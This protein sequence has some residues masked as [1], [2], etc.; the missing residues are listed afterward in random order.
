MSLFLVSC[1]DRTGMQYGSTFDVPDG[2][3]TA[4][5]IR[6]GWEEAKRLCG[7]IAAVGSANVCTIEGRIVGTLR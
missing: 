4:N 7:Q 2:E 6:Q 1:T 5:V 3:P